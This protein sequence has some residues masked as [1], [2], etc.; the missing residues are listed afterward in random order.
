MIAATAV[1]LGMPLVTCDRQIH[2]SGI[3]IIW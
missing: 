2:T 3:P 1:A